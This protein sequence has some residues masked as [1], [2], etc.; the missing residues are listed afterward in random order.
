[1]K[2][3]PFVNFS[4]I[5]APLP[6]NNINTDA[7]IPAQ[8]LRTSNADLAH[9]LFAC[10]RYKDD[11]AEIPDFIL[12]RPGF[13]NAKIILGGENFGCGSSREAAVWALVRFG[14]KA[15]FAPSFAD[16]FYENAFR[17]GL[18]AGIV[19]RD[20]LACALSLMG[21][22]SM[23]SGFYVD[24]VAGTLTGRDCKALHFFVPT[25]RR[26]ALMRG[27][28]DITA[29][30]RLENYIETFMADDRIRRPWIYNTGLKP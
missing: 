16:I 18:L 12:N 29:T 20:D 19:T 5:A 8:Y 28:D 3:R 10:W 6:L 21:N 30:L 4:G 26:D 1:M 27:D 13:R 7:I 14:I 9:G 2:R 15:V 23:H 24:L 17:N 11:D 22:D 25:F